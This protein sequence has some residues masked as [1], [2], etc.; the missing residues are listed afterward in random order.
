MHIQLIGLLL[1]ASGWVVFVTAR[2]C[3]AVL[4]LGRLNDDRRG[5]VGFYLLWRVGVVLAVV[6]WLFGLLVTFSV[7]PM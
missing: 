2:T 3:R 6:L 4:L 1:V 7:L 5:E